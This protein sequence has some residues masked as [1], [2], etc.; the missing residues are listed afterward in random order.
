LEL[1]Y[2]DSLPFELYVVSNSAELEPEDF[3]D[4][5]LEKLEVANS[6]LDSFLVFGKPKDAA[7]K[8]I[9]APHRCARIRTLLAENPHLCLT[10]EGADEFLAGDLGIHSTESTALTDEAALERKIRSIASNL[11]ALN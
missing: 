8:W 3:D 7:E 11:R 10:E 2:R 1:I 5:D 9:S 6:K 4:L